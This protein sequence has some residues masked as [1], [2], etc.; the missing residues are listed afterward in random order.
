VLLAAGASAVP[1]AT[2]GAAVAGAVTGQLSFGVW[3]PWW[4][5]TMVFAWVAARGLLSSRA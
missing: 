1:A 3:Q 4:I 2:L 5:A